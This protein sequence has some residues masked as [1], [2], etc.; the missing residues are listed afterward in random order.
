MGDIGRS[1]HRSDIIEPPFV[2]GIVI[3]LNEGMGI[4]DRHG[5]ASYWIECC[6]DGET[7]RIVAVEP[8]RE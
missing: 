8:P 3:P 2:H 7:D 6:A 4:V 1:E 5:I